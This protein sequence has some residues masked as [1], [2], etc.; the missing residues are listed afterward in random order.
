MQTVF[1][2]VRGGVILDFASTRDWGTPEAAHAEA[3][4]L[5]QQHMPATL[6]RAYRR[7]NARPI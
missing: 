7:D 4:R 1:K 2:V 3:C 6:V 5:R